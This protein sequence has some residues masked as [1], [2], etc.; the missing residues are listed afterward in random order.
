MENKLSGSNDGR[1]GLPDLRNTLVCV[2][3]K[4]VIIVKHRVTTVLV[5]TECL[6]LDAL[7]HRNNF[8]T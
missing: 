8:R 1:H 2:T 3:I 7:P 6:K 4:C 5:M